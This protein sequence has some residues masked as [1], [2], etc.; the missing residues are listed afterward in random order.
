MVAVLTPKALQ[1][2]QPERSRALSHN[3]LREFVSQHAASD[4]PET[5]THGRNAKRKGRL[6][7]A[8]AYFEAK[9]IRLR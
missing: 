8:L 6:A 5:P 1:P 9:T 3:P 7:A 2:L 4:E